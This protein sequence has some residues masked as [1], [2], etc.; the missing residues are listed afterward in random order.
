MH[1]QTVVHKGSDIQVHVVK[2][3]NRRGKGNQKN[4]NKII[5]LQQ[6]EKD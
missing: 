3:N 2:I 6:T 4:A 1:T 5:Q